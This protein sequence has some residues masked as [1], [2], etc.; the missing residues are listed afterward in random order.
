[1][2]IFLLNPPSVNDIADAVTP[3]PFLGLL[4]LAAFLEKNGY[5]DVG[6]IDADVAG[7]SRQELGNLL[8]KEAPDIVGI[9]AATRFLPALFGTAEITREK[10]PNSVI[11]AGGWG[12]TVEPEKVLGAVSGAINF[13]VIREGEVTLLEL[14]K[15]IESGVK[16]F[17]DIAGLA[18]LD[19]DNG[20]TITQPRKLIMDLDSIPWPAYH[21]LY[22]DFSEYRGLHRPIKGMLPPTATMV[23]TRG[24][25]NR[26]TYCSSGRTLHRSRSPKDIVAEMEFYKNKFQVRSIQLYDDDFIGLTPKQNEWVKEIC[27]EIIKKDLHKTLA[28]L[29]WGRCSQFIDMETLKK[30]REANFV[31]IRWGVESGSQKVLDIV[32]KDIQVPNIIRAFALAREAGIQ[33]GAY[34][35]VGIP[36]ETPADIKLTSNLIK[37]IKPD[38][39]SI[40]PLTPLPGTEM[41]KYLEENNL[42]EPMPDN[43]KLDMRTNIFHHTNEMTNEE[44]MKYYRLLLF[45]FEGNYWNFIKL[46]AKSLTTVD[47]W[48]KLLKRIK[49]IINYFLG[50]SKLWTEN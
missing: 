21:L 7:L 42:L 6:I 29:A 47:G 30:M 23:T 46:G 18:F 31:W 17:S 2:K 5:T 34:I 14:V 15:R 13:V 27:N 40:H 4:Y 1:M 24:C 49:I 28:F 20:L 48:K 36:G 43:Y 16:N 37:K 11:I 44:I 22:P 9:T 41:R 32:K 25:P 12:P 50:W 33:S 19:K 26:C 8:V 45:R 10:L 35:M 3:N 39:V 38:L